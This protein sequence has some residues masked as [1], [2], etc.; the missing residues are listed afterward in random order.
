MNSSLPTPI[1]Q[2]P[3]STPPL[4]PKHMNSVRFFN[5]VTTS[6][7]TPIEPTVMTSHQMLRN[8]TDNER[9]S[10]DET[11]DTD[12]DSDTT[13]KNI[14]ITVCVAL[15]ISYICGGA[16]FFSKSEDWTFLDASYFCFITLST[17]GFGDLVPGR[18]VL[19]TDKDGQ[20]TLAVCALYL[21]FGMALVAMSLNLL[22][23]K[24]TTSVK[25]IGQRI[26]ILVS[27]DDDD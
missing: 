25:S 11:E 9:N 5:D 7:P 19:S 16:W 4:I 13:A 21:C 12:E 23:E 10:S 8:M 3:H 26:G 17:I 18:T 1:M 20:V 6:Q 15:L 24:F 2:P 14:P 22:K 27:D